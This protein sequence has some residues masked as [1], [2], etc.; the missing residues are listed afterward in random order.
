MV[1]TMVQAD[2]QT[3]ITCDCHG[4]TLFAV[5]DEVVLGWPSPKDMLVE[6]WAAVH[7]EDE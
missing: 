6:K 7:A 5:A 1:A 2:G 4:L 3:T